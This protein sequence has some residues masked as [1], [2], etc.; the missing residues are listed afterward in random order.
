MIGDQTCWSCC[1]LCWV[2][3][4]SN[5]QPK[6]KF[7]VLISSAHYA[8]ARVARTACV[9]VQALE[10]WSDSPLAHVLRA[11]RR[12]LVPTRALYLSLHLYDLYRR[13]ALQAHVPTAVLQPY[14]PCRSFTP[15]VPRPFTPCTCWLLSSSRMSFTFCTCLH[16]F[17]WP[18]P[19]QSTLQ[20]CLCSV[21]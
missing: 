15:V 19:L 16:P 7:T 8:A 20:A 21:N 18:S 11:F 13:G 1:G 17:W 5:S 14:S 2:H 4:C 12:S 9:S 10:S 3:A 6:R